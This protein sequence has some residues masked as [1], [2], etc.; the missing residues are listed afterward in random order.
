MNQPSNFLTGNRRFNVFFSV[1]VDPNSALTN[2]KN[3]GS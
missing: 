1:G 2:L 3:L